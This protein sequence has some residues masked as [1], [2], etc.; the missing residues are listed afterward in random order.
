MIEAIATQL[1][2]IILR[3]VFYWPGWLV[4]RMVTFGRYPPKHGIAH[5]IQSVSVVGICTLFALITI[6]FS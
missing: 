2:N 1:F 5:N 6:V 4:L 3:V